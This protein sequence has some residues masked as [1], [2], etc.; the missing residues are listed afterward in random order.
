MSYTQLTGVFLYGHHELSGSRQ[1]QITASII[2]G[3]NIGIG[4]LEYRGIMYRPD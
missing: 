1:N 3:T 2:N 4:S